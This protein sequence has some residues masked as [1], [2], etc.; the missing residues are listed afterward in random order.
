MDRK[1]EDDKQKKKAEDIPKKIEGRAE[2]LSVC[3]WY[4]NRGEKDRK[5]KPKAKRK[6]DRNRGTKA[7]HS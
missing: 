1:K 7:K 3:V 6:G 4:E 2:G 5:R